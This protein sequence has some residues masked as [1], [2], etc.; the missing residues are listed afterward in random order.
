MKNSHYI[1]GIIVLNIIFLA[2]IFKLSH[3]AGAGVLISLGLASLIFV[4][5]PISYFKLVKATEDKLLKRVYLAAFITF[6]IDLLGFLFKIQHWPGAGLLITIGIPLP[7]ILFL[8]GYIHFHNVRKL[9]VDRNFFGILIFMLYLAVF[10]AFLSLGTSRYV[11]DN[12]SRMADNLKEI[13]LLMDAFTINENPDKDMEVL[14]SCNLA[15]K[16]L[17]LIKKSLIE[18]V[19]GTE[20]EAIES[21][22]DINAISIIGKDKRF[23]YYFADKEDIN[24]WDTFLVEYKKLKSNL[25]VNGKY[26]KLV[27][28]QFNSIDGWLNNEEDLYNFIGSDLSNQMNI[29][30]DWQNKLQLVKYGIVSGLKQQD[31]SQNKE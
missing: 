24:H 27:Q 25:Q 26:S 6:F 13:N 9:K 30:S 11:L 3:L 19:D 8:P 18:A 5:L 16:E 4:F 20:N 7:F 28:N 23:S 31:I 1:F 2:D 15:I 14:K 22:G 12:Q 21:N 17:E 10:S 29:L